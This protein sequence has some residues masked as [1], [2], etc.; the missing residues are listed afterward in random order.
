MPV[1]GWLDRNRNKFWA[2]DK[3]DGFAWQFRVS[4]VEDQEL[5]N[6]YINQ[7][8]AIRPRLITMDGFYCHGGL[9]CQ[10]REEYP[11]LWLITRFMVAVSHLDLAGFLGACQAVLR[12]ATS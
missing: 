9:A 2:T 8:R 4:E 10:V 5:G 11:P 7:V 3:S 12:E 1:S 6:A